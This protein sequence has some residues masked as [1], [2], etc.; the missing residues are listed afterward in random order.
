MVSKVKQKFG[1]DDALDAFGVHG[2]GGTVGALLTGVF[3]TKE[4]NDLWGGKPMG[5]VDGNPGQVVSQA[6]G[7]AF[8]II[9]G[10]VGTWVILKI[11]DMVTGVRVT[12]QDEVTG[13]DLTLHGEEGY[14][15]EF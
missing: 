8:A 13:L 9:L 5:W 1:Y 6:V 12:P 4:V 11:C 3:A 14:H 7:C 2:V 10:L 15:L